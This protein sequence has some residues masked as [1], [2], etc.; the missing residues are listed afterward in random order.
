MFLSQFFTPSVFKPILYA[1]FSR[2]IFLCQ[3]FTPNF[4]CQTFYPKHVYAPN[5]D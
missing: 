3:F 4:L 5:F 1:K 2:Q